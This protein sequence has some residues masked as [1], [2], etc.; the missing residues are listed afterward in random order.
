MPPPRPGR[1]PRTAVTPSCRGPTGS[2][3]RSA[4]AQPPAP[5]GI[6][7]PHLLTGLLWTTG[8]RL[9]VS[10][11]DRRGEVY[12]LPRGELL[13][14][15]CREATRL[16]EVIPGAGSDVV[17]C[18]SPGGTSF[19]RL[20][21]GPLGRLAGESSA[22]SAAAAG[23]S[24]RARG[25]QIEVTGPGRAASGWFAPLAGEITAVAVSPDGSQVI[26]GDSAGNVGVVD[27]TAAGSRL[28]TVWRSPDNAPVVAVGWSGG[29][30]ASTGSGQ[31]WRVPDC[32]DCGTDA[33][34]IGAYRA[35]ASGCFSTRQAQ[36][37]SDRTMA[38]LGLRRC[39]ESW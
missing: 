16:A 14:G 20:P 39:G 8:N 22:Q 38:L 31:T 10:S 1:S 34:L 24:V 19:W 7:V 26:A 6:T 32:G 9:A 21:A 17:A 36:Y 30:V 4:P 15:I 11:Q 5:T 35:R 13:G 18:E 3:G 12:Y 33:G 23:V 27:P 2:S 25:S 28:V 37:L 29:P